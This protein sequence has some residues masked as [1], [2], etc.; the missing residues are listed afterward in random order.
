MQSY[1]NIEVLDLK[2]ET[3]PD[4][5]GRF[6]RTKVGPLDSQVE[7]PKRHESYGSGDIKD[8]GGIMYKQTSKSANFTKGTPGRLLI[9]SKKL[10]AVVV[11]HKPVA[12]KQ[13][14]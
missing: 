14:I 6:L 4:E 12:T 11:R 9:N 1:S 10:T 8:K 7:L 5:I 3:E 13:Y 2:S